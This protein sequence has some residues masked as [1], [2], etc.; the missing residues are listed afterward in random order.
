VETAIWLLEVAPQSKT[1]K[2]FLDHLVNANR[3]ANPELLRLALKLA[4]GAG[5]TTVMAMLIVI[6]DCPPSLGT[7]P[8]E[9]QITRPYILWVA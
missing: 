1:D 5:K 7:R 4:T 3:D 6:I 2:R 9:N 8:P